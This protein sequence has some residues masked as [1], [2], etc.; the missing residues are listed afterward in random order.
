MASNVPF[1]ASSDTSREAAERIKPDVTRIRQTVYLHVV[2]AGI[3][4]VTC[5]ETE[6]A[7]GMTHQCCSPRF[8]ELRGKGDI[9]D[10]GMRRETRSGRRAAVYVSKREW[11]RDV[12]TGPR[13]EAP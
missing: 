9:F 7:L 5:D 13:K 10:S 3:M 4:G 2:A 11:V 6:A 1:V 12:T 8:T